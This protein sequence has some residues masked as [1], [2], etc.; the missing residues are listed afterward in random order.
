MLNE[1][2]RK[3][4]AEL[5]GEMLRTP[6]VTGGEKEIAA[7]LCRRMLE[8]GFDEAH[9]D[10]LGNAVGCIKGSGGGK[11]LLLDGHID[12]VEVPRPEAWSH[13]PFGGEIA[14]GRIYGRGAADMKCALAAMALA[15][16]CLCRD[17]RP[18]GDV[19]VSGTALEEIA[20]GTSLLHVLEE[21]K[22]DVVLIGEA[23][24]LNLN[25]GQR[26]RAEILLETYGKSAHSSNPEIGVNAVWKMIKLL[27]KL[28]ALPVSH[29]EELGEGILELTDIISSPYPGASVVPERCTVTFDRRLLAGEDEEAV[30]GAIRAEIAA[31]KAE[32]KDFAA[33][34]SI[35]G[36]ELAFY[37][38]A[39]R[40]H[41]K[42]APAWHLDRKN[43]GPLVETALAALQS[44]G[45]KPK[46]SA[47]KFCTNGSAS[48]G[49]LGIPTLGFGPCA[50][51]QAHVVD[52]YCELSE[53]YK[54]AEG[55]YALID[56]LANG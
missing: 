7:L 29:S 45:L 14:E 43:Q 39:T 49:M 1:E 21:T 25:I 10:E 34:V 8:L 56:A 37:T 18:K 12:T 54:A 22:P 51:W 23:T 52:E 16:G 53:V 46:V 41:K 28:R 30:L 50:E 5:C 9:V 31:L 55:Y 35:A 11:T 48:A 26:G 42:F 4:L 33:E 2:R 15:A 6:S 27:E 3:M 20:E 38:G 24:R 36:M 17:K 44:T 13:P 47:Y 32:D 19:Y 40:P